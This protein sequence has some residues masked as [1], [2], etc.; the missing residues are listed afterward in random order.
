MFAK[1]TISQALGQEIQLTDSAN[2]HAL[3]NRNVFSP[4]SAWVVYDTRSADSNFDSC[5]IKKVHTKTLETQVLYEAR[6]NAKVGVASYHPTENKIA[7]IHGP[8]FPTPEYNYSATRRFGALLDEAYPSEIQPID[9]RD[10]TAPFTPGALRGGTHVHVWHPDGSMMSYTYEDEVLEKISEESLSQEINIRNIGVTTFSK[11]V[12]VHPGE[13]NHDGYFSVLVSKTNAQAK[14]GSDEII[15]ALEEGWIGTDGY[16]KADGQRQKKALAFQGVVRGEAGDEFSEVFRLDLPEDLTQA[17]Q[18][19]LEGT[20]VLRPAPPAGTTQ[21]RLTFTSNKKYP[22]IQGPRHWLRSHPDGSQIAYLAKDDAGIVQ[23]WA[24][25]TTGGEPSMLT[26]N[27]FSVQTAF[28]WSPDGRYLIYAADNSLFRTDLTE[29][30]TIRL[31]EKSTD[32]DAILPFWVIYSP[33][34][35]KAVY[36]REAPAKSAPEKRYPQIFLYEFF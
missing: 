13:R 6:Q 15:K 5:Y 33:D 12:S 28:D 9:A 26:Q 27:A 25:P 4:D 31:T 17:D 14:P 11:K 35:K 8:V 21:T 34:G 22:G 2:G 29:K 1:K 7:F 32:E 23:I 20:A 3:L 18:R 36:L 16:L 30:T 24:V 19:P 10:V